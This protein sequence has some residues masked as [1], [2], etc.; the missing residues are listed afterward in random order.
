MTISAARQFHHTSQYV[1]NYSTR[2][3]FLYVRNYSTRTTNKQTDRQNEIRLALGPDRL[4][5]GER[6]AR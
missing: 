4:G 5:K 1:R 2:G 3:F 6:C